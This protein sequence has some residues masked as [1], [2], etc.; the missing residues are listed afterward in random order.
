MPAPRLDYSGWSE[1]V[2]H[3]ILEIAGSAFERPCSRYEECGHND[4]LAEAA[5]QPEQA[6]KGAKT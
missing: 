2:H 6:T 1:T 3:R 5:G 4:K